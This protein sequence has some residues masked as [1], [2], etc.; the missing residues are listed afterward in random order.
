MP[1]VRA[2]ALAALVRLSPDELLPEIVKSLR[3][4]DARVVAG[5]AVVLGRA[6]LL[7]ARQAHAAVPNLVEAFQTD[8]VE[9]GRAVAWALGCMGDRAVVPWLVAAIEQGFV[10]QTA[11]QA[12]GR[13][14]DAR[15]QPALLAAL[16]DD[17]ELVRASAARALGRLH[18]VPLLRLEAM[19]LD[20]SPRVRL[21]AA[22]VLY[23]RGEDDG[24]LALA[25]DEQP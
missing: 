5:A 6:A 12:L 21:C 3:S 14:A 10:P 24:P 22:L 8:D 17:D 23:E 7:G 11:A 25:L 20:P 15:A 2:A 19:L 16:A 13:L 1:A 18:D 4:E 9:I